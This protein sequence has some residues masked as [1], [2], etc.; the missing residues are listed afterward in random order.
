M[1]FVDSNIPMYVIGA[2]HTHKL[3]ALRMLERAISTD[4]R[5]VTDAEVLQEILHRYSA[6]GRAEAIQPAFEVLL[7]VVDEVFPVDL[8]TVQRAKEILLGAR[9]LTARDSVHLASMEHNGA[10]T[11]MTFDRG[12]DAYPA[13][14][15]LS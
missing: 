7:G 6:I 13:V 10:E 12:F 2:S 9:G 4:H 14:R 11:I 3:D 1:I 5:L 15:R 8:A